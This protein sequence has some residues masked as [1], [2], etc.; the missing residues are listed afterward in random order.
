[1]LLE[2][3]EGQEELLNAEL[4][5][6]EPREF[7]ELKEGGEKGDGGGGWPEKD[8]TEEEALLEE[9]PELVPKGLA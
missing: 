9:N 5:E 6:D 1:M 2:L 3:K 8:D 4:L 7:E